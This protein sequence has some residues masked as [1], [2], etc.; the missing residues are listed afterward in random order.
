MEWEFGISRRKLAY[1]EWINNKVPL[2]ST[3]NYIQYP[4][5]NHNGKEIINRQKEEL[6][7]QNGKSWKRALSQNYNEC[8]QLCVST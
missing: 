2:Y 3:G 7:S 6:K 5:I 8:T 4:V 1:I